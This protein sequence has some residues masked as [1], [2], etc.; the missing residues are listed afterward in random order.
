MRSARASAGF[1]L[2]E[3]LVVIVI[4]L[5]LLGGALTAFTRYSDRR[6][7]SGSVEELKTYLQSAAAKANAGDLDACT[8]LAGYRVQTYAVG[9]VTQVAL[10]AVCTAGTPSEAQLNELPPGITVSPNLNMV[11]Q[12]LNAG[13]TL[14]E[15]A[16]S[17]NITV[18]N[19]THSYQF[20][21]FREGRVS[22][23]AWQ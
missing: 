11:F 1:S 19:G 6:A 13:V 14:P 3:L 15:N 18:T 23:G 5:V 7:V 9:S 16:A 20:T 10:Q 17:Q 2:I 8:Q 21:I 22:E 4:S 12:V